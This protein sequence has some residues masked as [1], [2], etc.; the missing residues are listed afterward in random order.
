MGGRRSPASLCNQSVKFTDLIAF[1]R[2][3]GTSASRPAIMCAG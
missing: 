1:A 2:E 3:L